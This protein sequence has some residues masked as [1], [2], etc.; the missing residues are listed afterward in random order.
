MATQVQRRRGTTTEHASFTGAE[1][2]LTVDTTK[3]T[4]VVHDGATAGGQPL[5]REDLDNVSSTDVTAKVAAGTTSAAGKVQLEDSTTSTSTT[6]AATPNSV[7]A[8]KDAADAAQTTADAALPAVGGTI[9]TNLTIEGDLT[10]NGTTTT[11]DTETLLV[12]DKNIEMGVVDTPTDI[13]A[14]GGGITLK[15]T[16]DKTIT[17]SD[18]TDAWTSSEPLDLPAGAQATPSLFFGGDV[19]SGLYSPGADQVAI[20]TG[21]TGRLFVDASGVMRHGSNAGGTYNGNIT[22]AYNDRYPAIEYRT[23]NTVDG[24]LWKDVSGGNFLLEN[25]TGGIIFEAANSERLRLTSTGEFEF[26]GAGT[27]GTTQAVYFNGSAPVDSLVIDSSGRLLV[28]TPTWTG[29]DSFVLAKSPTGLSARMFIGRLDTT[30]TTGNGVGQINFGGTDDETIGAEIAAIADADWTH[31]T[32]HPTRL[33]F[34]TTADGE[35]SPTARMTIKQGGN[36]GIGDTV[37]DFKL[38]VNGDIGIREDNNLVFHDGS[39]TAAFR[40]RGTSDNKLVFERASSN[41]EQMRIDDGRLLVGMTSA[42]TTATSFVFQLQDDAGARIA[43]G[44]NDASVVEGNRIG[45]IT[46]YGNSDGTYDDISSIVCEADGAHTTSG[47]ISKPTRLVFSTTADSASSP[48]RRMTIKSDGKVGIGTAS[49]TVLLDLESTSP[50]IK[51]TDSDATGT[52]ECQISGAGGDLTFE[53]DRDNEKADSIINFRVDGND[54]VRIDSSG[55]L[56]VGATSSPSLQYGQYSRLHVQGYVG[57]ATNAGFMN[58]A[59]GEGAA[60]ITNTEAL[61]IFNFTDSDGNTFANIQG[62]A[63]GDAGTNNY[64]GF[65][66]FHTNPGSTTNNPTERLRI[67][68]DGAFGL[69][70]ANYGT[71]GQV[72]T[73]NG[74]SAAPTWQNAGAGA[75]LFTSYAIIAHVEPNDTDGGSNVADTWNTRPI[76]T[77]LADPDGIVTISSNQF[78]LNA[79]TYLIEWAFSFYRGTHHSHRLYDATNS[80][81]IQLGLN[82]YGNSTYAGAGQSHGV[83]RVSPTSSTAYEIQMYPNSAQATSDMGLANNAA[84]YTGDEVYLFV[85]IYKES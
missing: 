22:F 60:N 46:F 23:G 52:P 83:A 8:A 47:T 20:S 24:R 74:S 56:L 35:S 51:L 77:E 4:V 48:N 7:K 31:D 73:S 66:A 15:G 70:G 82:N 45:E 18:T 44:R 27:A 5:A 49:P 33:V 43:I 9:T 42:L 72:L 38:D 39:G 25:V 16:T 58:L 71:S 61:G 17:W 57:Q 76:N 65:L 32:S 85:K 55:R 10:V 19:N 64:P 41:E 40:I 69:S 14:D 6:T 79:G 67:S 37:P 81:E 28:G 54:R 29:S 62:R 63:D 53:A 84:G 59:R 12:K 21:G 11:I 26:T 34:S 75:G 78:T 80:A 50:T 1:G 13:T 3:D 68:S 36:V 30:I 2:E